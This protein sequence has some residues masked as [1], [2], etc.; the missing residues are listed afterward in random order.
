MTEKF[1]DKYTE[2]HPLIKLK[3]KESAKE[4]GNQ[5]TIDMIDA[6]IDTEIRSYYAPPHHERERIP[7]DS[8]TMSDL[9]E[10]A[11]KYL[12]GKLHKLDDN[13]TIIERSDFHRSIFSTLLK[14]WTYADTGFYDKEYDYQEDG[15]IRR[16]E[17][18]NLI[19]VDVDAEYLKSKAREMD[20]Y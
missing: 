15:T 9:L 12:A 6:L 10:G 3:I 1:E 17:K 8:D 16:D 18:G 13:A 5:A 11:Y 20:V 14:V 4:N 2:D 7:I 19:M